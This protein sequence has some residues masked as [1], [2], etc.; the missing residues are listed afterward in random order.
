MKLLN[1]QKEFTKALELFD[2]YKKNNT[3]SLSTLTITQALKA[4]A[5]TGDLQRG[6]T[7]HQFLSSR[8]EKNSAILT[9]L[10]H[11]YSYIKNN[12]PNKAIDLFNQIQNPDKVILILFF[13]ACAQLET[14]EALNLIKNV[15]SKLQK[16]SYSDLN[17]LTS[18]IDALMKCGDVIHAQSLFDNST[19]KTLFM[20]GA[21]MKGYIKNNMPNKAI[22]LFNEIKN[23]DEVIISLLFD[24]CA[25]L[26]TS[27]ALHLV[28]N[29][30]SKLPKSSYSNLYLLTSLIDALMKCGDV[31]YA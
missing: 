5:Q 26:K 7:I 29:V 28:K 27:K 15:S 20:Y 25:E 19:K 31:K 17:L 24:A 2:K 6:S 3:Q 13:N 11:F 23:P 21:M 22:D 4:C 14:H 30:L 10:I 12:M 8:F 16:P 1:N 9:S 18:L